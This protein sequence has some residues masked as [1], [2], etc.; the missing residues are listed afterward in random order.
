M[1]DY[2]GA[3]DAIKNHLVSGWTTTPIALQNDNFTTPVDEYGDPAPWVMLE[4]LSTSS[5]LRTAGIPGDHLWMTIGLIY[6]HVLVPIN[7]GTDLAQQYA[8]QIGELFRAAALY[9]DEDGSIVRTG[10]GEGPRTDGGG[11]D[12][13]DGNWFRMTMICEFEFL[14]RG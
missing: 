8:W 13:D 7:T 11:T 1:A 6:V 2:P 3:I 5:S 14:F 12:A 4:V 9:S 10:L